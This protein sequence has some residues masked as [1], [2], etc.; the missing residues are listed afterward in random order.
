MALFGFAVNFT[1]DNGS[2]GTDYVL[3]SAGDRTMARMVLEDIFNMDSVTS[4]E[5]YEAEALV[6]EQYNGCATLTTESAGDF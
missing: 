1:F 3:L 2:E 5:D 4:V 6:I